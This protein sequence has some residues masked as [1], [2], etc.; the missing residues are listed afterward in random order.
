MKI[1]LAFIIWSIIAIIFC[2]M[3]IRSIKSKKVVPFF[4]NIEAPKVKDIKSFNKDVSILW[5][6][7]AI[8]VEIIAIS[9]LFLKQTSFIYIILVAPFLFILMV[10]IYLKIE[11][12]H[13]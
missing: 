5:F 1:N 4:S 2:L 12:K 6:V 9:F 8:V 7:S 13:K 3:G 11:Q 10:T